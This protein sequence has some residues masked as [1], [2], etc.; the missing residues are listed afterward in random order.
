MSNAAAN[1]Y[2][3]SGLDAETKL[4]EVVKFFA[5][6]MSSIMRYRLTYYVRVLA[7]KELW[8]DETLL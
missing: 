6:I 3:M 1:E 4:T 7:S 8:N 5:G 2:W